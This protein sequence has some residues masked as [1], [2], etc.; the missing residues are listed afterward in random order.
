V[1]SGPVEI[2]I[3]DLRTTTGS[4]K[5]EF[6]G[7]V[8]LFRAGEKLPSG[9]GVTPTTSLVKATLGRR[10]RRQNTLFEVHLGSQLVTPGEVAGKYLEGVAG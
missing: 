3:A 4:A 9:S 7:Q 2:N 6:R 8:M 10:S 5:G 1:G